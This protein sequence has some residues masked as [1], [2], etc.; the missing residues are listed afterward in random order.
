MTYDNR[1]HFS[2]KLPTNSKQGRAKQGYIED[3]NIVVEKGPID[4]W[5]SIAFS[6]LSLRIRSISLHIFDTLVPSI[7]NKLG[8]F[9]HILWGR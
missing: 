9:S 7:V 5:L 1:A 2:K 3:I 8:L 4:R 6:F